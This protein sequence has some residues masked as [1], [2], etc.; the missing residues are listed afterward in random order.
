MALI[1][2][3]LP[4]SGAGGEWRWPM[5]VYLGWV[6]LTAVYATV[7]LLAFGGECPLFGTSLRVKTETIVF[8]VALYVCSGLGITAGAHR[9]WSHRSY[10]ASAPLKV[11]LMLFNSIANQGTIL[12]WC[13]DH[14]MH[15]LYTDTDADPHDSRRGVW[16]THV[17]WLL[18]KRRAKLLEEGKKLNIADL[19]ADRAVVFQKRAGLFWNLTWC[20]AFPPLAARL[21]WGDTL[22]NGFLFAGVL[23]YVL[24]LNATWSVNSVAHLWGW[25]PYGSRHSAVENG[26]VALVA[27]GEG[28]HNWHHAFPYDYSA[29]ELGALKQFNPTKVFIDSMVF[30][31]LAWDRKTGEAAWA[32]CKK[33]WEREQGC[34]AVECLDGPALFKHRVLTAGPNYDDKQ[35]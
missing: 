7:V 34:A 27:L 12:G 9:L 18:V 22:W 28:W 29:A 1:R 23:R 3:A 10:K 11:L 20:F 33:R 13:R 26:W 24:L 8:A 17:G 32:A 16:F 30:L 2:M 4:S 15:H 35:E 14:R 21:L 5:V 19:Y 25:K 31:G 6:H